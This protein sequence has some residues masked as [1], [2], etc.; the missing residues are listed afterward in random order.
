MPRFI[1]LITLLTTFLISCSTMLHAYITSIPCP[2]VNE[3][4]L[5]FTMFSRSGKEANLRANNLNYQMKEDDW[6]CNNDDIR[7][8]LLKINSNSVMIGKNIYIPA[9]GQ[10]VLLPEIIFIYLEE[11]PAPKEPPPS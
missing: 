2:K 11:L 6:I 9:T 4:E 10:M 1:C 7:P 3:L 5:R 8:R